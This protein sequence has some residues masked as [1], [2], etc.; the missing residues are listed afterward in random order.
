[1]R[2]SHWSDRISTVIPL[3]L[4]RCVRTSAVFFLAAMSAE[5]GVTCA[6]A[7]KAVWQPPPNEAVVRERL[8]AFL[9]SILSSLHSADPNERTG[10]VM[11]L[12][13]IRDPTYAPQLERLA[14]AD[15]NEKV[16]TTAV[17]G[18]GDLGSINSVN[19]LLE[20]FDHSGNVI[21]LIIIQSVGKLDPN[22]AIPLVFRY[23][24]LRPPLVASIISQSIDTS[25]LERLAE[26]KPSLRTTIIRA[27]GSTRHRSAVP[28]LKTAFHTDQETLAQLQKANPP[29]GD[30]KFVPWKIAVQEQVLSDC[31]VAEV[32]AL[33]EI[34]GPAALS[35]L[36]EAIGSHLELSPSSQPH[37]LLD[38]LIADG[39]LR[40]PV[41]FDG[42]G[43]GS[44]T[45]ANMLTLAT[46]GNPASI[47]ALRATNVRLVPPFVAHWPEHFTDGFET[48]DRP[49]V[50]VLND[51]LLSPSPLLTTATV[52]GFD[53]E[54]PVM[55][56]LKTHQH[57]L[58]VIGLQH[59][60]S[61]IPF[62]IKALAIRDD[63]YYISPSQDVPGQGF[64]PL[65]G[66]EARE[67][68]IQFGE[69]ALPL[70]LEATKDDDRAV[71]IN[72]IYAAATIMGPN[73]PRVLDLLVPVITK[74]GY[75]T[76]IA[77]EIPEGAP[78]AALAHF[79]GRETA[80]ALVEASRQYPDQDGF[81]RSWFIE[82][83]GN[84]LGD[85]VSE[86]DP[87]TTRLVL[88][89]LLPEFDRQL[90]S[91]FFSPKLVD[92]LA[93]SKDPMIGQSLLRAWTKPDDSYRSLSLVGAIGECKVKTAI[94][95]VIDT[96]NWAE[97]ETVRNNV[98]VVRSALASSQVLRQ[99]GGEAARLEFEKLIFKSTVNSDLKY[100]ATDS[101]VNEFH[102][103]RLAQVILDDVVSS[104]QANKA[105]DAV[106]ERTWIIDV[107]YASKE[108]TA[109]DLLFGALRSVKN[110]Y[111]R[112]EIL[113]ALLLK[114]DSRGIPSLLAMVGADLDM[115]SFDSVLSN[116]QVG[117]N[118]L[119][120]KWRDD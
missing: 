35:T 99:F 34:Q 37:I 83:L 118:V 6:S 98:F 120:A 4:K 21:R 76:Y 61:S 41:S 71:R 28:F 38:H 111:L 60:Q 45:V 105:R 106:P 48:I 95:I 9:P 94:P 10:A 19:P 24:Q 100:I 23:F 5:I 72:A 47:C 66:V 39:L 97:N 92:A 75:S 17:K 68:L 64:H 102:E 77:A 79:G 54:S 110:S 65:R 25:S 18:L 87:D 108:P 33:S 81:V 58:N 22:A 57:I 82:P 89:I 31:L 117:I 55:S 63:A 7:Q 109:A 90:E 70:L 59:D 74:P 115:L 13:K 101:L 30:L 36:V 51:A 12:W 119:L 91:N 116:R 56:A 96:I 104:S 73:D 62:L 107:L 85:A 3:S 27:I 52:F 78:V 84:A 43:Q 16:Q 69:A 114:Q 26:K 113:N 29:I 50:S 88:S 2:P 42:A 44:E 11:A 32:E 86:Q 49:M 112:R 40:F 15:R 80:R 8:R 67:V 53:L 93:K 103:M 14:E 20:V 1:M 46:T